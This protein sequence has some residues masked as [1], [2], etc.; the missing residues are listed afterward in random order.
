MAGNYHTA[1]TLEKGTSQ[2]GM[3][4]SATQYTFNTT[5]SNGQPTTLKVAIPN[6]LPEL[7]YHVGVA[8]DVEAGGR[9]AL[10]SLGGEFDVKWRFLRNDK[11]HLAIDP[12][13]GYQAFVLI[14]GGILRLPAILTYELTD[15]LD[16]NVAGFVSETHFKNVDNN[17][18]YSAFNGSLT[19][20]GVSIGVDLHGEVMSIRP[21]VEVTRYVYGTGTG[22]TFEP[23]NLVNFMVHIAWTG[24]REK[25]QLVRIERKI[26]NL[27]PQPSPY[28]YTPQQYPQQPPPPPPQPA[29][30]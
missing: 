20:T 23:F 7:T 16:F 15:T 3:T 21:A 5:D 4:F 26:D 6:L 27:Q 24:G 13:I 30:Q 17:A 12:A 29:P 14:E 25:K 22:S 28:P 9:I 8:D 19:G 11:L 10:G 18:D 2:F 1:K